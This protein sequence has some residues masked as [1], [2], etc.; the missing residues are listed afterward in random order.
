MSPRSRWAEPANGSRSSTTRSA[1]APGASTPASSRWL[2]HALPEVYAAN[3]TSSGSACSGRNGSV[4]GR[5]R[6]AVRRAGHGRVDRGE[7]VRGGHGPVAAR[8][9]RSAGAVQVAEGVLPARPLLPEERDGEVEHL[10]VLAGPEHLHVG[11]D[12]VPREARDVVGVDELEVRDLVP[13]GRVGA[14]HRVE[15]LAH[16]AVADRV[17]VHLEPGRVEGVHGVPR[18]RPRR[19]TSGRG[20][21]S[22]GRTCRGTARASRRSRSPRPRPA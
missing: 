3:A 10:L 2:A 12:A 9:Q 7:R 4:P 16:T 8:D 20:C 18:A 1:T 6:F 14:G 15:G 21:R 5:S 17:D 19:R 11:R 13:P 22:R